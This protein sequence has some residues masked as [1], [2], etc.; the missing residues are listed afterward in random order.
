MA[1]FSKYYRYN[2]SFRY[3]FSKC[4]LEITTPKYE[5]IGPI[6]KIKHFCNKTTLFCPFLKKYSKLNQRVILMSYKMISCKVTPQNYENSSRIMVCRFNNATVFYS[7][8]VQKR[9]GVYIYIYIWPIVRSGGNNER[10]L[11]SN[12]CIH[13]FF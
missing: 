7:H 4:N 8:F 9:M 13:I 3:A 12:I 6:Y 11:P 10:H 5:A 2:I 1:Q